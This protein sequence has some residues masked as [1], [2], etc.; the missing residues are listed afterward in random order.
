MPRRQIFH[1]FRHRY[2]AWRVQTLRQIGSIEGQKLLNANDWEAVQRKG[3]RAI[4]A[5]I[6]SQMKGRSC[7]VVFIGAHTAHRRW[8]EYEMQSGWVAGKG[9]VGIRI[10]NVKNSRGEHARKGPN[11]LAAVTV[12]TRTGTKVLSRVANTYD[13]PYSSSRKVYDHIATNI[14]GWIEEAIAIRKA[15]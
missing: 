10:H 4:R 6:D 11:P 13:P 8:V 12:P 2:D 1:S 7:V 9:V 3:P 15:N 5:W 14:E